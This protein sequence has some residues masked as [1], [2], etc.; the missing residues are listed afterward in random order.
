MDEPQIIK[1]PGYDELV[2]LPRGKYDALIEALAEAVE[3]LADRLA[4]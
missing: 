3:E 1:S 4:A 2:V